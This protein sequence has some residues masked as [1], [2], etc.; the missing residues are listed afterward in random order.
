M[1]IVLSDNTFQHEVLE[2]DIPV[3]V[4][5]FAEWCGPCKMLAPVVE[6]LAGVYE[7]KVKVCK[8]DVDKCPGLA[9]QFH[10]Q[11]VPTLAFFKNG[12]LAEISAGALPKAALDEKMRQYAG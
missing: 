10:V 3:L 12:A 5:F 7:G 6:E 1:A 8:C 2:S 9:A 4:D 11:A